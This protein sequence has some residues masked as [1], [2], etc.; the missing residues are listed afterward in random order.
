MKENVKESIVVRGDIQGLRPLPAK[1]A[2]KAKNH[3]REGPIN[4]TVRKS[5]I[6]I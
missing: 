6:S 3:R 5:G 4:T 2:E 1:T